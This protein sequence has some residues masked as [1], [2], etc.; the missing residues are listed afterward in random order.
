MDDF[1]PIIISEIDHPYNLLGLTSRCQF[2]LGETVYT[3]LLQYWQTVKFINTDLQ[4]AKQIHQIYQV[5][6][7][8][9][10]FNNIN[11]NNLFD[12]PVT[13]SNS[14]NKIRS[15]WNNLTNV[16]TMILCGL[17][18]INF[19]FTLKDCVMLQGICYRINT[20]ENFGITLL[21]TM[22]YQL[23]Y[24]CPGYWG[25]QNEG[26]N[27]YGKLLMVARSMLSV[28]PGIRVG[29]PPDIVELIQLDHIPPSK[30]IDPKYGKLGVKP[31]PKDR[32][33]TSSEEVKDLD[34]VRPNNVRSPETRRKK[35]QRHSRNRRNSCNAIS[36][37]T[38]QIG[39]F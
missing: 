38:L 33:I 31:N 34:G 35:I 30:D 32:V 6:L 26:S 15:D 22:P 21:R 27:I 37:G 36:T 14:K 4:L 19:E 24:D 25:Y 28:T 16:T 20:D 2:Q 5:N 8:G 39:G 12:L 13:I 9:I 7:D 3:S 23:L 17:N 10:L 1:T 11:Q 18:G 29:I